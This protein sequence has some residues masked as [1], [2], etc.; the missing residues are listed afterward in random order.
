MKL[1][2]GTLRLNPEPGLIAIDQLN[3]DSPGRVF[4]GQALCNG[5]L[6]AGICMDA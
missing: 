1:D 5:L 3:L 4:S 2:I 6:C